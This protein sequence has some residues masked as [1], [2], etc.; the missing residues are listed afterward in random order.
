MRWVWDCDIELKQWLNEAEASS[1]EYN[2]ILWEAIFFKN[3]IIRTTHTEKYAAG[4]RYNLDG[5]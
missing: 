1:D 4:M 5:I 3:I 2:K